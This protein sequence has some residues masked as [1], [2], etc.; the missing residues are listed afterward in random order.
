MSGHFARRGRRGSVLFIVLLLIS[1][2]NLLFRIHR[3][4]LSHSYLPLG[5]YSVDQR[6]EDFKVDMEAIRLHLEE[7]FVEF[8]A[9][10]SYFEGTRTLAVMGYSIQGESRYNESV[11]LRVRDTRTQYVRVVEIY[12]EDG[13]RFRLRGV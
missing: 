5:L 7:R 11:F 6:V 2:G 12:Y 13:F 4:D 10:K 1:T 8:E 9:F 3:L